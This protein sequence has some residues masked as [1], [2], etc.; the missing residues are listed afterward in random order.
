MSVMV[1]V[2]IKADGAKLE[3][4]A[5]ANQGTMTAIVEQAKQHGCI[6]HRFYSDGNGTVMVL[7]QW[8]DGESFHAFF[9]ASMGEIGPMMAAAGG[10]G[11]PE[12]SV[13]SELET[14][15]KVGWGA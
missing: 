9:H 12:V 11:E 2:R 3:E 13:W 15:D 10:Q 8:P 6:A 4:W 7:D 14:P 5:A 1:T